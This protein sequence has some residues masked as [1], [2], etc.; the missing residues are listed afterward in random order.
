MRILVLHSDIAED[1]PPEEQDTL[2]AAQAVAAALRSPGPCGFATALCLRAARAARP[3]VTGSAGHCLQSGRGRRRAGRLA[4]IAPRLLDDMGIAF[5]GASAAAMDLTNDKPLTKR[6]LRDA[7]LATPDWSEPPGWNGLDDGTYIVKSAAEDASLGLDDG[8]VVTGAEAVRR[9]AGDCAARHGGRW[10]AERFVEGREFNI[11]VLQGAAGPLIFPMAEMRFDSWPAGKP[12]IVG[13]DA[14]WT[15][16]SP[17]SLQTV[18]A[19]GVEQGEPVLAG[20]L[21]A[22]CEKVWEIFGLSGFAR[23]DFR[24]DGAG[25]R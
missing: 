1:A 12:R 20:K 17:A 14:K 21:R 11:A 25:T 18:R 13:Y 24:V 5:T 6:R 3:A 2:V 16:D 4:P 15:E 7:G 19:F 22:A 9:R 23:V 10:F 8:C